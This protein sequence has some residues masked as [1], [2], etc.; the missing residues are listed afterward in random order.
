MEG[1]KKKERTGNFTLGSRFVSKGFIEQHEYGCSDNATDPVCHYIQ[2][3][4]A[5]SPRDTAGLQHFNHPTKE[6]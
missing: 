2:I 3:L 5:S 4:E 1:E 6:K